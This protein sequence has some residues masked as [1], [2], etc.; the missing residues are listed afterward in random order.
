M[1]LDARTKNNIESELQQIDQA[2]KA[3]RFEL[4]GKSQCPAYL[5]EKL[6]MLNRI[7]SINYWIDQR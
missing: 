6:K 2:I 7:D 3:I 4:S 1:T 5:N